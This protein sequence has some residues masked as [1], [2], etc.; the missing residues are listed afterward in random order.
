MPPLPIQNSQ[1]HGCCW[2]SA[3]PPFR[4][5]RQ[6]GQQTRCHVPP[7]LTLQER[8]HQ[9]HHKVQPQQ[10]LDPT[11]VLQ[12]H[13]HHGKHTLELLMP[14]LHERLV[15]VLAQRLC[16]TQ[17]LVVGQQWKQSITPRRSLH[18]FSIFLKAHPV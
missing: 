2:R 7:H 13:R 4:V 15:F 1:H 16:Q 5:Q 9:F 17:R 6:T 14:L 10:T 12:P 3:R 11:H 18:C 8:L